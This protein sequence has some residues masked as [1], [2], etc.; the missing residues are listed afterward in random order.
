MTAS[1]TSLAAIALHIGNG[2]ACSL[3]FPIAAIAFTP[4][5]QLAQEE[6]Q[7]ELEDFEFWADQCLLLSQAEDPQKTLESCEQAITLRPDDENVDL[8]TARSTALFD[9]QQ[10]TEAI[11]SFNRVVRAAPQ[12]SIAL[13]YQCAAYVQLERYDDAIDTCEN[14]LRMNGNW[15]DRSP[16][17][18][19]YH[20]GLALLER[21][22]LETALD[23]FSR[24]A[25][26]QPEDVIYEANQC[27]LEIELG[28]V[29]RA[30]ALPL[31]D[32]ITNC[33]LRNT[34][35]L[36]ERALAL[37]PN[38]LN[39]WMQQGLALE[40]LGDYDRALLSY[41]Q[42][43]A[44]RPDYALA[45]ARQCGVLNELEA[46]E[47]AIAACDA[48]LQ[49]DNRWGRV[50]VAYGWTQHSRALIGLADYEGALASAERAV[51]L[52]PRE[53]NVLEAN[54]LEADVLEADVLEADVL[55]A[56]GTTADA[57][58]VEATPPPTYPPAWNNLAVS[59][60]H[61]EDYTAA[62]QAIAQALKD[63]AITAPTLEESFDRSYPES[64][65]LFYRGYILAHYN[66]GRILA[67]AGAYGPASEAYQ[68]ALTLHRNLVFSAQSPLVRLLG[69]GI[70]LIEPTLEALIY[71]HQSIAYLQ[72]NNIGGS[73]QASQFAVASDPTSF[74]A[75]YNRGYVLLASGQY[76]EALLA[77]GAADELQPD[78]VYV[79]TGQGFSLTGLGRTQEAL[80]TLEQVVNVL[81]GYAPAEAVRAC[82]VQQISVMASDPNR[83]SEADGTRSDS[84]TDISVCVP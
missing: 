4:P 82:I 83:V 80:A 54:V 84:A 9:L 50:G 62:E 72:S 19:W 26:N 13:A 52:F 70:P 65:I 75:Q 48:A 35:A 14:A 17:F 28:A 43:L 58:I 29:F 39:L 76:E 63:Y 2:L 78:N 10:Y 59:Y 38:N 73:L 16:G 11:A 64:P 51:D 30:A 15:G 79:L 34:I 5:V 47:A 44:M 66:H 31:L 27:A 3:S 42:A 69:P 40:Q 41:E 21:G 6:R 18:A 33:T 74:T 25:D 55:E 22:R 67:S 1:K 60:W 45:L 53:A 7:F 61:L 68:N 81:P 36:Y 8:W 23:S 46:F 32:A 71:T 57:A 49:G 37:E 12:D 56:D 24:A 77:F 20:R